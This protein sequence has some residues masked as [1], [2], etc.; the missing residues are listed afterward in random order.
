[1]D[2]CGTNSSSDGCGTNS[3]FDGRGTNLDRRRH[4]AIPG[5]GENR[6]VVNLSS[7]KLEPT[8]MNV[9]KKGLNFALAPKTISVDS[10]IRSIE[11]SIQL[12]INEEK[13][14]IRQ[15]CAVILRRAKP[16]INNIGRDEFLALKNLKDNTNLVILK[17]DKGGATV[18]M[19]SEDYKTKM[20]EHLMLS[21]S[22]KRLVGNPIAKITR[23]V[24][25]VIKDSNLDELTKKRL[26]PVVR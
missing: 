15:D 26:L 3:N 21:G 12:L 17:A 6:K 2:G 1:L 4:D 11:D 24:K 9:L 7:Q 20:I 13:E 22:Y 10:I 23:E 18:I 5:N 19:N 14:S 16:P 25:K 8:E